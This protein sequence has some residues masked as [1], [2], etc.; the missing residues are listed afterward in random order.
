LSLSILLC[1]VA[2]L[3]RDTA[4]SWIGA[5]GACRC[6]YTSNKFRPR[7]WQRCTNW[8]RVCSRFC[9]HC[10]C[11]ISIYARQHIVLSLYLLS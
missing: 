8:T 6:L 1:D 5:D 3:E 4:W 9:S 10:R 2:V 7:L 11:L